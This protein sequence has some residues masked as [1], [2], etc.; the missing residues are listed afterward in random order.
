[1]LLLARTDD[2]DKKAESGNAMTV[3]ETGNRNHIGDDTTGQ[4]SA[5]RHA[6]DWT[7]TNCGNVN[8]DWRQ[9][10]NK[11]GN[12]KPNAAFGG[13]GEGPYDKSGSKRSEKL[14][15]EEERRQREQ[16]RKARGEVDADLGRVQRK[17]KKTMPLV[18]SSWQ[19][20]TLFGS[21]DNPIIPEIADDEES[22]PKIET[23]PV[24]STPAPVPSK[25]AVVEEVKPRERERERSNRDDDR[26]RDRDRGR[27]RDSRDRYRD[28][29]RRSRS[30]SR[31]RR[32]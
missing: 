27:E 30:R 16:D 10:C 26:E 23:K 9:S 8:W 1:M 6:N 32:R 20:P 17:S 4:D 19:M 13:D 14:R 12:L 22:T 11:C 2:G 5:W 29:R 7:C 28:S 15:E 21:I 25:P 3:E 31:D 24:T 18:T